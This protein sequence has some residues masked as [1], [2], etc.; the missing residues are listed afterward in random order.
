MF[1]LSSSEWQVIGVVGGIL[2]GLAGFV[3]NVFFKALHYQL[4][5]K[6]KSPVEPE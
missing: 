2:L 1:G 5:K 3:V 4:A 6:H